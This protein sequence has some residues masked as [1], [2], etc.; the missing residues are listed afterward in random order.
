MT[1]ILDA[2]ENAPNLSLS[3]YKNIDQINYLVTDSDDTDIEDNW[4]SDVFIKFRKLPIKMK[5]I[6]VT[7]IMK[8][9]TITKRTLLTKLKIVI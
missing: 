1:I 8:I 3:D 4:E 2:A 9:N 5:K 6:L 7:Q